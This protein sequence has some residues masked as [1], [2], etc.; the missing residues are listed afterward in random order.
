MNLI[1]TDEKVNGNWW[2]L[3]VWL[4]IHHKSHKSLRVAPPHSSTASFGV[5]GQVVAFGGL[6][7]G[8]TSKW[9]KPCLIR[10][11]HDQPWLT[12]KF[13][14][15][16]FSDKPTLGMTTYQL[17]G[18]HRGQGSVISQHNPWVVTCTGPPSGTRPHC[19]FLGGAKQWE[20]FVSNATQQSSPQWNM[21]AMDG[22]GGWPQVMAWTCGCILPM[23]LQLTKLGHW[24]RIAW[25]SSGRPC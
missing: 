20:P 24:V 11:N 6:K 7:M 25:I 19:D 2:K 18:F 22:D 23:K 21:L 17:F 12:V 16:L 15:A 8:N 3:S 9:M 4:W 10:F 1:K 5:G 14:R 13:W